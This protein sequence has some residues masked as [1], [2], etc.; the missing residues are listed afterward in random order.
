MT[1]CFVTSPHAVS[2]YT[3]FCD[4]PLHYTALTAETCDQEQHNGA[5]AKQLQ[6]P[7]L[8]LTCLHA[9]LYNRSQL[10]QQA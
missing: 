4:I 1:S 3:V 8:P 7:H 6:Q 10:G 5:E 9:A 2:C